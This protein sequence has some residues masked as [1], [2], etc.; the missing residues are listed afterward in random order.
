MI[1]KKIAIFIGL[2]SLQIIYSLSQDEFRQIG[3]KIWQNE[4]SGKEEL[5]VFWNKNESFPSLGIGHN[6]W[7]P[8]GQRAIYN[9]DFP[10]LCNYLQQ[11][12]VKLPN[13]LE[14][15]KNVGAPWQSREEFYKDTKRTSELRD[16]LANTVILQTHFMVNRL[17][18][19]LPEIIEAAPLKQR[20]KV[21]Y[22]IDLLL[23]T[24]LGT[25]AVIDYLNFKG[26]GL[27]T[28]SGGQ[29]WGLLAV[30][31]DMPDNLNIKNV[32][33]AFAASAAKKLLQR[34]ANDGPNYKTIVFLNG[35]MKRISTYIE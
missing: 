14:Q 9:Q 28:H 8:A 27:K 20:K 25:Y 29:K 5:L 17:I 33:K 16:L 7:F 11:N 1:I 13:W 30:L 31:L 2:F 18:K 23:S 22:N 19:K 34:I 26:D 4:A 21:R 10:Q 3:T 24:P 12:G 35:W 6:I 32:H 15:A